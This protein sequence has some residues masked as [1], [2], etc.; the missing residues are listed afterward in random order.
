M[1]EIIKPLTF[2]D[3]PV[4]PPFVGRPRISE[5]LQQTV[6]LLVGWDKSTRRLV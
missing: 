4:R 1:L 2:D 6:A 3:L 5:D